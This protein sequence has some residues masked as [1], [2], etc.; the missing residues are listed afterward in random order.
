MSSTIAATSLNRQS[1]SVNLQS[2]VI[3]SNISTN[4]N[5]TSK[6]QFVIETNNRYNNNNNNNNKH[7]NSN[8]NLNSNADKY[9]NTNTNLNSHNK[10]AF[11]N[12]KNCC[13]QTKLYVQGSKSLQIQHNEPNFSNH[14]NNNNRNS[15]NII[16]HFNRE[17]SCS[18]GNDRNSLRVE[19]FELH[20]VGF[21]PLTDEL[22][23]LSFTILCSISPD[24]DI[25][26]IESVRFLNTR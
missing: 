20:I 22:R 6:S 15:Y 23:T 1:T 8:T 17:L 3:N 25:N 12:E 2:T 21:M 9:T 11:W 4:N 10:N 13:K 24:V 18:T 14:N 5:F 19:D 26:E 16:N 7:S